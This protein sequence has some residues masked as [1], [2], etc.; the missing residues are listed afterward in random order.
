MDCRLAIELA[1]TSELVA[2]PNIPPSSSKLARSHGPK[3]EDAGPLSNGSLD[4]R[5]QGARPPLHANEQRV[6]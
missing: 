3:I 1:C 6:L 5:A 2:L 4:S